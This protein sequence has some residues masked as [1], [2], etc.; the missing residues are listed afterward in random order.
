M[1]P[2][3]G[4]T[5]MSTLR[6]SIVF[7]LATFTGAA[8]AD[9]Q[10]PKPSPPDRSVDGEIAKFCTNFAPTAAE[11][12]IAYQTKRLNELEA[13]V[14]A[15]VEALEKREASAREW[16]SKR[17]AMFKAA[18][19]DVVAVYAKM[20][21]EAAAGQIATMDETLAAGILAKLKPPVASA[22]LAEMD[23]DHAGRL[24]TLMSGADTERKS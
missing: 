11:A 17:D 18:S 2:A 12:R 6:L 22:I 1:S 21:A 10:K 23:A 9:D 13:R 14:R 20:S 5:A 16:V 4:F 7:A 8:V 19:D 3:P 15:E 24:T